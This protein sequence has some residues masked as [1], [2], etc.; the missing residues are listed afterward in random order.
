MTPVLGTNS[1]FQ[2]AATCE[3]CAGSSLWGAGLAGMPLTGRG[4]G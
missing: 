2:E 4:T 3:L 1:F